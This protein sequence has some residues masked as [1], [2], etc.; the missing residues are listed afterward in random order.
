MKP[1][2]NTYQDFSKNENKNHTDVQTWLLSRPADTSVTHDTDRETGGETR[3]TDTQTSSELDE[4][5]EEGHLL[6]HCVWCFGI[7]KEGEGD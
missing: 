7:D 1:V 2:K 3:E 6:L 4:S 5:G